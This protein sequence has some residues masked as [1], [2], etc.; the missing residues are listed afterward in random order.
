MICGGD[1]DDRPLDLQLLLLSSMTA[2]T[3]DAAAAAIGGG[4][5]GAPFAVPFA[6]FFLCLRYFT[7][8]IVRE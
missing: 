3:A 1:P 8:I 2:L 7:F 6:L 4:G 5:G